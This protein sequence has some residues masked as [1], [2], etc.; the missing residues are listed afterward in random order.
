MLKGGVCCVYAICG[1]AT[2]DVG[3]LDMWSERGVLIVFLILAV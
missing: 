3:S 1:G 2:A